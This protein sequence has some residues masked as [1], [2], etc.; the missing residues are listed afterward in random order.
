MDKL[1]LYRHAHT[2]SGIYGTLNIYLENGTSGSF[3][4]IENTDK[5]IKEGNYNMYKCYSPRFDTNLWTI[6]VP[7]RTGIRIHTANYGYEL[8]GCI[9]IGLFKTKDM[10]HQS[11]NAIK[12]LNTILDKYKTYKIQIL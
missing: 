12:I 10:I 2:K 3:K 11:R 9:G 5:K 4:T 1:T 7:D 6:N 8:S